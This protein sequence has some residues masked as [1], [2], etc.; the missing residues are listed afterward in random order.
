V[1]NSAGQY[2]ILLAV[3]DYVESYVDDIRAVVTPYTMPFF[4]R[5]QGWFDDALR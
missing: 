2:I 4:A 1:A 3:L 5:V